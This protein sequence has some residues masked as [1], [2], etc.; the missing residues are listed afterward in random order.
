MAEI[1]T[2]SSSSSS[3]RRGGTSQ[4]VKTASGLKELGRGL[5]GLLFPELETTEEEVCKEATEDFAEEGARRPAGVVEDWPVDWEARER[6]LDVRRS[7]IVEAPAGSGKTSLLTQR[8]LRL[9]ADESVREPEQVLA[10]TFTRLATE[11]IRERVVSVLRAAAEGEP[12]ATSYAAATRAIAER[13]LERDRELGWGLLDEPRR[14]RVRTIDALCGEI[15]RSMPILSGGA[16]AMRPVERADALYGEAAR[17]TVQRLGGEDA[18]LTAA[19]RT[20]LLHRDG[21]LRA[22]ERLLAEMLGLREQWGEL[23]P[24]R[25]AELTEDSLERV[26]RPQLDRA[27]AAAVCRGLAELQRAFPAGVFDRLARIAA[28][29][30][31]LPAYNGMKPHPFARCA[32]MESAPEAAAEYLS[33]WRTLVGLLVTKSG[34]S[35]RSALGKNAI[36]VENAPKHLTA[37]LKAMLT[38][39]RERDDLMAHLKA[40]IDLPPVKYPEEQWAVAKALFLVLRQG[41]IELQMVFAE[42]GEC[43]F[44]E[45]SLLARVALEGGP[46]DVES[47]LGIPLQHLL[48]DEAQDTST[49][50][51]ELLEL[52]TKGWAGEGRTVFLVGDPKQSIYLF[53]QARVERF[54]EVMRTGRLGEIEVGL[55]RLVANFRSQAGLVRAFN[56]DFSAIFGRGDAGE[57]EYVQAAETIRTGEG[58]AGRAGAAWHLAVARGTGKTARREAAAGM[59]ARAAAEVRRIVAE[60]QRRPLPV[61]RTEPWTIAVLVQARPSLLRLL[62][63]LAATPERAAIPFRAVKIDELKERREVLD[64]LSLTRALLHPADKVAWWAVLRAPWCGLSLV[65]LHVLAGADDPVFAERTVMDL[66]RTRGQEL[67][68]ESLPRLERAWPVLEAA[69]RR[70]DTLRLPELTERTWRSLG[71]DAW[72]RATER[73]NAEAFLELLRTIDAER[74]EVTLAEVERRMEGLFAA[75]GDE[76]G[77]VELQTIHGSKGLEWDVVIVPELERKPP[78]ARARLLE[79]EELSDGG[80]GVATV[81]LAPIAGKGEDAGALTRWLRQLHARREAAERKRLLYV[82][83]TRAQTELHLFGVVTQLA[84]GEEAPGS[85]SLL[86]A[87]WPAAAER[88]AE[89][90]DRG[91]LGAGEVI[92]FPELESRMQ[93]EAGVVQLAA[94]G[95]ETEQAEPATLWRLPMSFRPFPER[96]ATEMRNGEAEGVARGFARPEGSFAARSFGNAV[97]ALL[98]EATRRMAEGLPAETLLREIEGWGPRVRA[99]LRAEGLSPKVVEAQA[100]EV[101][102][103]LRTTVADAVGRWL[104]GPRR[105]ARSELP[106]TVGTEERR[107]YRIDR[108]FRAGAEP[109]VTAGDALWIVDYKTS[110]HGG[111]EIE[112]FLE[113]ERERYRGQM[114]AYARAIGEA[115][116]RLG[117]WFPML[118]R[119]MWWIA[120]AAGSQG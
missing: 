94:A 9:L 61:G 91:L 27:L 47:A 34:A 80:E 40:C 115:E 31:R 92:R 15:A 105:E 117:L 101:L 108:I 56:E 93:M 118:G 23:L 116:V 8:Y 11:E 17:R 67:G 100:G 72:L 112:T 41:L 60:W 13:V 43:D 36:Q 76:T 95:G 84:S 87:A 107:R 96:V 38:E 46:E 4:A 66:L 85:G 6:A 30:A 3:R 81:M 51:Y 50:Q 7:W 79:W 19:L 42:R 103:G 77:A 70:A 39:L 86:Q 75:A 59:A 12:T 82:A 106:L 64:L 68:P 110:T 14:L 58:L 55:L 44:A 119:L 26:V 63:E 49:R 98:E 16:S 54:L 20:S 21:D 28:E 78:A 120:G 53:R 69:V 97:H 65:D 25:E 22:C 89:G 113:G 45:L 73:A 71:G 52:L 32:E 111:R 35:W 99:V 29:F 109:G 57:V 18:A 114:E 24:L 62:P 90:E 104:L 1:L 2:T 33:E 83:C 10:I 88:L 48:V 37:E 74:G 102:S 5:T